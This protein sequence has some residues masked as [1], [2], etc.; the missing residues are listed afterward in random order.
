[1]VKLKES[2]V[3]KYIDQ[4]KKISLFDVLSES[5]FIFNI[6]S[7]KH[8]ST[9]YSLIS[10]KMTS[11]EFI[12]TL[13]PQAVSEF[14]AIT[15]ELEKLGLIQSTREIPSIIV[16]D[17]STLLAGEHI[18]LSVHIIEHQIHATFYY[19]GQPCV[20][21]GQTYCETSPSDPHM[22][23]ERWE[24][25]IGSPNFWSAMGQSC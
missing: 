7:E 25:V 9:I 14:N 18:S 5:N 2:I 19:E 12:A 20:T 22:M 16:N 17:S 8:S 15:N 6:I 24:C 21:P 23:N 10:Q 13:G 3:F 11:E 1:M 4:D